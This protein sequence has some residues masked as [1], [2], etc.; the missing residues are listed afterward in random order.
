MSLPRHRRCT[1]KVQTIGPPEEFDQHGKLA[2][3]AVVEAL[4]ERRPPSGSDAIGLDTLVMSLVD[5]HISRLR[6]DGRSVRALDTNRH[7]T[8]KLAKFTAGVWVGKASPARI[9]AALYMRTAHR[10]TNGTTGAEI[11]AGALPIAVLNNFLGATPSATFNDQV[12]E[13]AEGSRG[14]GRPVLRPATQT[15]HRRVRQV[16]DAATDSTN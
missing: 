14:F 7:D 13:A 3:D 10:A 2:E 8:A 15:P 4:S 16:G 1:R 12:Q 5:Q 9:E 11:A 6:E